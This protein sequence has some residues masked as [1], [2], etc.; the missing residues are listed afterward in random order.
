M[1]RYA[2]TSVFLGSRREGGNG[3]SAISCLVMYAA[4]LETIGNTWWMVQM[5]MR[6]SFLM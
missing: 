1:V 4:T 2:T 6:Q 3:V 5:N